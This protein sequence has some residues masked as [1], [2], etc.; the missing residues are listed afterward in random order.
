MKNKTVEFNKQYYE[1]NKIK[2]NNK[3]SI[4]EECVSTL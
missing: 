2:I 4:K 3:L 1:K